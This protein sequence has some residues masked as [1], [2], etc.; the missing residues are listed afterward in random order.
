VFNQCKSGIYIWISQ[1][2]SADRITINN[3]RLLAIC[4]GKYDMQDNDLKDISSVI[5]RTWE[6]FTLDA[7]RNT[8]DGIKRRRKRRLFWMSWGGPK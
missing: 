8:V 3:R 1:Q 5:F 6:Y 2:L 7:K 4:V